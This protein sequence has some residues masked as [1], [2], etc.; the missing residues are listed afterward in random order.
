MDMT[1]LAEAL[2]PVLRELGREPTNFAEWA[3][4]QSPLCADSDQIPRA[5][6]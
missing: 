2:G 3:G 6:K 4:Y 1:I 5:V